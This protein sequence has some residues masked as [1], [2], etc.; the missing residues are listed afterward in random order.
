MTTEPLMIHRLG[1]VGPMVEPFPVTRVTTQAQ[2]E[3]LRKAAG[4]RQT[5]PEHLMTDPAP[6]RQYMATDQ[7]TPV[8][9]VGSVVVGAYAWCTSMFV[10][11]AYRRRGIARSLLTRML[12]DDAAA[13]AQ[14]SVLLSSHAGGRL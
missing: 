5:L 12:R 4:S 7:G 2:A 10:I 11:P 14:A 6:M 1:M 8:G 9:W 13:G 3:L